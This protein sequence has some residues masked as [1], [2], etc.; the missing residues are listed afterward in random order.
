VAGEQAVT[1]LAVEMVV[2]VVAAAVS[3]EREWVREL[4]RLWRLQLR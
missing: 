4:L 2:V 1:R 3:R